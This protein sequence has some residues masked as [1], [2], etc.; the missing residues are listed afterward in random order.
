[1]AKLNKLNFAEEAEKVIKSLQ[2]ENRRGDMIIN[3]TSSKIRNMLAMSNNLYNA[4][5]KDRTPELSEDIR[6]S[7]QYIKMKFAY[8]AGREKNVNEF[9]NKANLMKHIDEIGSSRE[10]ALIF[11]KYMESLVAYHRF[12]SG[13]DR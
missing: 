2:Y 9:V 7:I 6:S 8:E 4:V 13:R 11:C 1:M 10:Q 5:M 12:H 3:I